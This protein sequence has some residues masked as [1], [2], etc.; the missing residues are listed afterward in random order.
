MHQHGSEQGYGGSYNGQ[1]PRQS[2]DNHYD[3]GKKQPYYGGNSYANSYG[4]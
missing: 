3:Q 1:A 4:H 2:F